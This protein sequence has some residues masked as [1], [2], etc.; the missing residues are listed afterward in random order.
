MSSAIA[1]ARHELDERRARTIV[2]RMRAKG[3][4]LRVS[5]ERGGWRWWLSNGESVPDAIARRVIADMNI[6]G[7]GDSLFPAGPCQTYRHVSAD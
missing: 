4:S 7:V 2:F 3:L 1:A 6:V 5:H